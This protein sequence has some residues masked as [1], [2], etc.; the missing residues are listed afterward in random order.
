MCVCAVVVQ[1]SLLM[2]LNPAVR[3]RILSGDQYSIKL[4]SLLRTR[5]FIP[6]GCTLGI[7]EQLSLKAVTE[8]CKLM[9]AA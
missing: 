8:A 5:V 2:I 3:V 4:R 1:W 7:P 6:P 9:V